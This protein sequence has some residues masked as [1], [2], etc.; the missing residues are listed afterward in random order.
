MKRPMTEKEY[1][2]W[3]SSGGK[4]TYGKDTW[5]KGITPGGW[6]CTKPRSKKNCDYRIDRPSGIRT[7][8]FES[9]Y[10]APATHSGGA[11]MYMGSEGTNYSAE[12][13]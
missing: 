8:N 9:V 10:N 3:I 1:L 12:V 7:M 6:N 11:K 5:A 4:K 2:D 13:A